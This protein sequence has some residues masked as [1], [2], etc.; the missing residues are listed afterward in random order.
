MRGQDIPTLIAGSQVTR[1]GQEFAW[2]YFKKNVDVFVNKFGAVS[3]GSFQRCIRASA[4]NLCSTEMA[5]DVE[6]ESFCSLHSKYF[7]FSRNF[8]NPPLTNTHS[9]CSIV[10]FSRSV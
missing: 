9:K 6:V 7:G 2:D 1:I 8:V 5:N 3:A 4:D 10:Q